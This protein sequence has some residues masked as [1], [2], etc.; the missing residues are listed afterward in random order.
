[1][2]VAAPRTPQDHAMKAA[3]DAGWD[4][5]LEEAIL[6]VE[7]AEHNGNSVAYAV[8]ALRDYRIESSAANE[9]LVDG[10]KT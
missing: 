9:Q 6:I 3:F 8:Q 10:E 5:A 2:G 1:M 4:G 7:T